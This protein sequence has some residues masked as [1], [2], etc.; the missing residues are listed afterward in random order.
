[1]LEIQFSE[2]L[3]SRSDKHFRG[4]DIGSNL[5]KQKDRRN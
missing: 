2:G 5:E 3:V 4:P 1:M